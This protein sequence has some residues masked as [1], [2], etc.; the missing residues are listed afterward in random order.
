MKLIS[1]NDLKTKLEITD[2]VTH[3]PI[4]EQIIDGMSS[5]FQTYCNRQFKSEERTDILDGGKKYYY[6]QA[7]PVDITE[8]LEVKIDDVLK[9]KDSDYWVYTTNGGITFKYSTSDYLQNVSIKYTGGYDEIDGVLSVPDDLKSAC[10]LQCAFE[11]QRRDGIGV[12]AIDRDRGSITIS[13]VNKLLP[14][15]KETLKFYRKSPG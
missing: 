8:T 1:L 12:T 9:V 4:L 15:V 11:F 5:N 13:N 6:L 7:Y 2:I 14:I 3:D 10:L